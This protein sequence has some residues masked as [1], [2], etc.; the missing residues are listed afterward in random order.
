VVA[1]ELGQLDRSDHHV[2]MVLTGLVLRGGQ[3]LYIWD[4]LAQVH[5]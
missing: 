3:V 4:L 2:E 1:W 5:E